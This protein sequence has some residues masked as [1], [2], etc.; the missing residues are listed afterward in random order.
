MAP[1]K[2]V[3]TM[4][5]DA[6]PILRNDPSISTLLAKCEE[7]VTVPSVLSE[8]KD[9]VARA[10]VELTWLPFLSL[11]TP[12]PGSVKF[13][14]E[15]ARKTGD[16]AVLSKPDVHILALAYEIECERNG[17]DWRLRTAPGQK[18]TNGLP[19]KIQSDAIGEPQVMGESSSIQNQLQ[20]T[21]SKNSIGGE[22]ECAEVSVKVVSDNGS[23]SN[24]QPIDADITSM[25]MDTNKLKIMPRDPQ[26]HQTSETGTLKN[27]SEGAGRLK[28][29]IAKDSRHRALDQVETTAET[30]D[31]DSS[32]SEGW[33]TP[34]NVKKHQARDTNSSAV[35]IPENATMQVATVTT[36]FAMQNVLLQMNLNLVS[37]T[38]QRVRNVKTHILRCHACFNLERNLSKQFCSRCGQPT[39]TRVSCSTSQN[40]K[41]SIH[42]KKNMQWSHRGDR[43]SIPKP[44]PG[45][46]NGKAGMGKGG[47]KGGWGQELILAEDQ[48]EYLRAI[49]GQRK[50]KDMDLMSEDS[51]PGILTGER[52]RFGSRPKIGGGRNVNSK[53]R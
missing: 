47:G 32:G 40:G 22:K 14:T 8:I 20:S 44:V 9:H 38:M 42:L 19:P 5:L 34:S 27:E 18:G 24:R 13:I 28:S 10:R 33:I 36:D 25:I 15:F 11:K 52:V 30:S 41:F 51:L 6:G 17:G 23:S 4:L 35:S 31:S 3:H 39:L 48:K 43:F 37:S 29:H 7:L 2:S 1:R 26:E 16:L 45:A 50:K 49:S 46:A 21:K 12:A 53:K